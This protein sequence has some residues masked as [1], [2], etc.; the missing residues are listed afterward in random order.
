[1]KLKKCPNC[2]TIIRRSYRYGN[3]VKQKIQD[4]E[5]VKKKKSESIEKRKE[6]LIEIWKKLFEEHCSSSDR[7]VIS[8]RFA[9]LERPR[10]RILS[11]QTFQITPQQFSLILKN[12][13]KAH[14]AE[15][16]FVLESF[17][18][19]LEYSDQVLQL[20]QSSSS[21]NSFDLFC[22]PNLI[23]FVL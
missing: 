9:L 22:Y 8:D 5:A 21:S 19:M 18:Q 2:N 13:K 6:E 4:L 7:S 1:V 16:I 15:Q 20:T 3:I 14:T 23:L 11:T 17:L 10:T 12:I